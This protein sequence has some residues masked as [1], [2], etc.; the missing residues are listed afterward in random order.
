MCATWTVLRCDK[1]AFTK[2]CARLGLFC[3]VIVSVHQTVCA[4]WTVLRCDSQR[5]PNSVRVLDFVGRITVGVVFGVDCTQGILIQSFDLFSSVFDVTENKTLIESVHLNLVCAQW[6][7]SCVMVQRL[8]GRL[9]K[10]REPL[11]DIAHDG[12]FLSERILFELI[13]EWDSQYISMTIYFRKKGEVLRNCA[14]PD[15]NV[16]SEQGGVRCKTYRFC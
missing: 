3:V 16:I 7:Q 15:E 13:D 10:K 2:Q 12:L 1:S 5:A 9:S 11:M 6:N 14:A 4:T 8:G